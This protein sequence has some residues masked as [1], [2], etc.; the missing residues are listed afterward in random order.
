MLVLEAHTVSDW[1]AR[2]HDNRQS[3]LGRAARSDFQVSSTI[4]ES[5][6]KVRWS[7]TRQFIF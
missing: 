6:I 1:D 3:Q 4:T 7:L 2:L 5:A